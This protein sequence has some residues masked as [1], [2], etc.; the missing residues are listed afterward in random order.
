MQQRSEILPFLVSLNHMIDSNLSIGDITP[1]YSEDQ[2]LQ[3]LITKVKAANG[4]VEIIAGEHIE[5]H[6]DASQ[7]RAWLYQLT[8]SL[9]AN[10]HHL[11]KG[12]NAAG[13]WLTGAVSHRAEFMMPVSEQGLNAQEMLT[14]KL[15]VYFMH[16]LEAEYDFIDP[17]LAITALKE[18]DLVISCSAFVSGPMLD[19]ADVI[20]PIAAFSEYA[21]S[22]INC[23]GKLQRFNAAVLPPGE[24]KPA[25]KVYRVLANLLELG[26]LNYNHCSEI[27][28][29]LEAS[30][31]S[32]NHDSF[33]EITE[34]K[35]KDKSDIYRIGHWPAV[36]ADAIVRR[37]APL[38]K[39]LDKDVAC[40]RI[41]TKHAAELGIVDGAEVTLQQ[42]DVAAK[43]LCLYDDK[44]AI[45]N[46]WLSTA[47]DSAN[48]LGNA[49]GK[50]TVVGV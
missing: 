27:T 39:T 34:P 7:I 47:I 9:G 12:A 15:P 6:V 29:I 10:L 44:L 35:Y 19:Y 24:A 30:L 36:R 20:L 21:G 42:G 37:A 48:N 14:K 2:D 16:G 22:F 13:A 4:S 45:G 40:A 49:Y 17:N 18:A 25:W 3:D 28:S 23:E 43:Y 11:T 38:Q 32:V 31:S 50:V 33:W 1:Q 5:S 8:A 46:I 41:N 26:E